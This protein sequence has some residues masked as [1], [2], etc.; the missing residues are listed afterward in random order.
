VLGVA[1]FVRG[2]TTADFSHDFPVISVQ[3]PAGMSGV[4]PSAMTVTGS[5][6]RNGLMRMDIEQAQLG[7]NFDF[8]DSSRLTS[9]WP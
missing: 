6:F 8:T 5:A 2:N 4:S 7:G 3:L 1:A 9:A